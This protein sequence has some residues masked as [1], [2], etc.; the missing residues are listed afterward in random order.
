[1]AGLCNIKMSKSFVVS[2]LPTLVSYHFLN[3]PT[4]SVSIYTG[5]KITKIFTVDDYRIQ[6]IK[7][8]ISGNPLQMVLH[9]SIQFLFTY[10]KH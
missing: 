2:H 9:T 7:K 4:I 1:M 8:V 10:T 3:H 5:N 6:K